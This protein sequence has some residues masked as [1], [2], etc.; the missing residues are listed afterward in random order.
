MGPRDW[1]DL[2]GIPFGVLETAIGSVLD[3]VRRLDPA[4]PY[5][6]YKNYELHPSDTP[7]LP[8]DPEEL[9]I[10]QWMRE[11]PG[12]IAGQWYAFRPP[13]S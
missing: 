5:L 11:H 6:V 13:A 7:E 4:T 1:D 3:Q 10:E 9:R 8:R 2:V 12:Q